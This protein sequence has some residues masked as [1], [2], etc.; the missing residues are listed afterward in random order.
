MNMIGH[1]DIPCNIM[2]L[3]FEYVK[4]IVQQIVAIGNFN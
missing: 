4:P 2:A 3:L 1:N